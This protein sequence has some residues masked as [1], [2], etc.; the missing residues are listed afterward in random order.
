MTFSWYVDIPPTLYVIDDDICLSGLVTELIKS[1]IITKSSF[2]GGEGIL[3]VE[4]IKQFH[5]HTVKIKS[6]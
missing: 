5:R 1:V 4:K 2:I 6:I 3:Y